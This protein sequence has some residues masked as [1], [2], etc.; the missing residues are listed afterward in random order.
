MYSERK[1]ITVVIVSLCLVM[2]PVWYVLASGKANY[3]PGLEIITEEKQ[4]VESTEWM[5]FRHPDLL[6]DWTESVVRQGTRTYVASD[7]QEYNISLSGTCMDCH[8]NKA[9]F[10]DQC[11]DYAGVKPDCWDCHNLP[12][13]EE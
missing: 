1:F 2:F 11:H 12:E 7:G 9:E 3:V 6:N 4:C 13:E 5:R 10:C 8:S